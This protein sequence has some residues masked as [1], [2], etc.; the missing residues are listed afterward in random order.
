MVRHGLIDERDTRLFSFA[1][2]PQSALAL[3]QTK[4]PVGADGATPAFAKS[5][6]P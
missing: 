3:L 4:L 6:T 5:R 2:D 1:D